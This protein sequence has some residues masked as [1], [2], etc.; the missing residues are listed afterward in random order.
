MQQN[1]FRFTGYTAAILLPL[2]LVFLS[3]IYGLIAWAIGFMLFGKWRPKIWPM[4]LFAA[5]SI[6]Q[7]LQKEDET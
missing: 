1:L 4:L 5:F 2:A 7:D 6:Q 3:P